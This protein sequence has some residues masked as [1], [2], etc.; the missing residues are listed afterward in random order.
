LVG[1]FYV[2]D[3]RQAVYSVL[4]S[5]VE[6]ISGEGDDY[7]FG[8]YKI[9][10]DF[11]GATINQFGDNEN[12]IYA[13][14]VDGVDMYIDGDNVFAKVKDDLNF[15]EVIMSEDRNEGVYEC[16]IGNVTFSTKNDIRAGSIHRNK[17]FMYESNFIVSPTAVTS[18]V[19]GN[20]YP[21]TFFRVE[22]VNTYTCD[23]FGPYPLP[24]G[25]NNSKNSYMAAEVALVLGSF[26]G[27]ISVV[28]NRHVGSDKIVYSYLAVAGKVSDAPMIIESFGYVTRETMKTTFQEH[29]LSTK[30]RNSYLGRTRKRYSGTIEKINAPYKIMW[31]KL[32]H[33]DTD[34]S[35]MLIEHEYGDEHAPHLG[36]SSYLGQRSGCDEGPESAIS[37][38]TWVTN[39]IEYPQYWSKTNKSVVPSEIY[40]SELK[41]NRAV[42]ATQFGAYGTLNTRS[43][44]DID[45]I[46][47][48]AL[49]AQT[50]TKVEDTSI[51]VD[52]TVIRVDETLH[53]RL[54]IVSI[55]EVGFFFYTEDEVVFDD[56]LDYTETEI[57]EPFRRGILMEWSDYTLSAYLEFVPAE[58]NVFSVYNLVKKVEDDDDIVI[59]TIS[60]PFP[61][62]AISTSTMYEVDTLYRY[63]RDLEDYSEL[64]VVQKCI[65]MYLAN[66]LMSKYGHVQNIVAVWDESSGVIINDASISFTD[67]VE[68]AGHRVTPFCS[69]SEPI[70]IVDHYAMLSVY[71]TGKPYDLSD[72][73][74]VCIKKSGVINGFED[75]AMEEAD[76]LF[77]MGDE[78]G[79]SKRTLDGITK[80]ISGRLFIQVS[81]MLFG[82]QGPWKNPIDY[83]TADEKILLSGELT[84]TIKPR[85]RLIMNFDVGTENTLHLDVPGRQFDQMYNIIDGYVEEEVIADEK[86]TPIQ[87]GKTSYSLKYINHAGSGLLLDRSVMID[88]EAYPARLSYPTNNLIRELIS[89]IREDGHSKK[90]DARGVYVRFDTRYVSE[91][92]HSYYDRFIEAP[93]ALTCDML[94][95]E[96]VLNRD[97]E[98]NHSLYNNRLTDINGSD[99]IATNGSILLSIDNDTDE[100]KTLTPEYDNTRR[101]YI[102]GRGA[103]TA[104]FKLD[105]AYRLMKSG[106]LFRGA[107]EENAV[108][109]DKQDGKYVGTESLG[110]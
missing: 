27:Y 14:R 31:I 85:S 13:M 6:T 66:T 56:I 67:T 89:P 94:P 10:H 70:D 65:P 45:G 109:R 24:D 15:S 8:P 12:A 7:V 2:E 88:L 108:G 29:F 9:R 100:E 75:G 3:V 74:R 55:P 92:I 91:S 79:A 104:S 23:E 107:S 28:N 22:R 61:D 73:V 11:N 76:A 97:H 82:M 21:T 46:G 57:L 105:D 99:L 44:D 102:A 63:F 60:Q 37:K 53:D 5:G 58:T 35:T 64:G 49:S 17:D 4:P 19:V 69:G 32:R 78:T 72:E 1:R 68:A 87:R 36:Y 25:H 95:E 26:D 20:V 90:M 84:Y 93:T 39:M 43:V 106:M 86:R 48:T 50:D 71:K 18:E 52:P 33:K 103:G 38:L 110:A 83:V 81:P 41:L 16:T 101:A 80:N 96:A 54:S 42:G 40:L 98:N 30:I 77:E 47:V 59:A 62:G 34:K 51:L